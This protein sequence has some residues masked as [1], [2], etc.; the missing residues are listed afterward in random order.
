MNTVGILERINFATA[1]RRPDSGVKVDTS[2]FSINDPH[3]VAGEALNRPPSASMLAAIKKARTTPGRLL[4]PRNTG[5][6][7]AR[8]TEVAM[9]TR[10]FFFVPPPWRW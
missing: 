9:L 10:R 7:F 4:N 3:A 2:Q 1:P 5:H 6:R 8:L